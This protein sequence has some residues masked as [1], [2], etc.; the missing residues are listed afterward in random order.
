MSQFLTKVAA[1]I[2]NPIITLLFM[3]ALLVLF[4]GIVEMI[5]KS[6]SEEGRTTGRKHLIWGVAGMFIM[7]AVYG[8]ITLIKGTIGI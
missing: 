8:I 5:W 3:S 7:V 1:E 2:I 6:D 4:W